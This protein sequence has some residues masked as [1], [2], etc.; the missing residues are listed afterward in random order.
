MGA[1]LHL[2]RNPERPE[3]YGVQRLVTVGFRNRDVILEFSGN[4]FVQ[5]VQNPE[6][7]IARIDGVDDHTKGVDVVH[8]GEAQML[9]PHLLINAVQVLLTAE[10]V[11]D[12]ALLAQV[13]PD[14]ILDFV[15]DLLAIP[16][17]PLHLLPDHAVAQRVQRRETELLQF[18]TDLIDAETLRD[19]R[20]DLERFPRDTPSFLEA[21]RAERAHVME[22]IRKFHE[23]DA[24]VV[25]HRHQHALKIT[26]LRLGL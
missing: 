7:A 13:A 24:N 11:R 3:Q 4:R 8:S 5:T 9:F 10:H 16:T 15:D 14:A 25:G 22:T 23:D 21:Q 12:D 1:D 6:C 19:R 18:E 20:I 17:N 2:D 26:R